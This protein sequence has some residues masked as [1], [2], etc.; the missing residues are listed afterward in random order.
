M[1][2]LGLLKITMQASALM[3]NMYAILVKGLTY[4]LTSFLN[5]HLFIGIIQTLSGKENPADL[6]LFYSS[7]F[8]EL[9]L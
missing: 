1:L 6:F 8:F 3:Q 7:F 9:E 5:V 4:I 2:L